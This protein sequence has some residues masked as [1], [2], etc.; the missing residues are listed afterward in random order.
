MKRTIWLVL[1]IAFTAA[2]IFLI[3]SNID[4]NRWFTK[5]FIMPML[6]G[7]LIAS[8]ESNKTIIFK[9]TITALIFS[10]AGD[11]LLMLEPQN[12]IFFIFGLVAFLIAHICYINFFKIVKHKEKIRT[13]WLLV[14]PIV[15]YYLSLIILL[16]SYLGNL[17]LPVIIYGFVI[18]TMFALA[19]HMQQLSQRKAGMS[20]MLGAILFIISDSV[21]AINKFYQ[22][23][24]L[25]GVIIMLTYA[26]AQLLIVLGAVRY[27]KNI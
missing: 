17:K 4:D 15:V 5:I 25:A 26:L 9:W 23:F 22:Q 18:S 3:I 27:I 8:L 16:F 2:D 12:N 10:W 13:N 14:V 6:A 11:V 24:D 19:L 7:Y 20:M 21:L 1:F